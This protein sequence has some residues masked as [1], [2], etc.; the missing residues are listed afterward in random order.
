MSEAGCQSYGYVY[1]LDISVRFQWSQDLDLAQ[2]ARFG[3]GLIFGSLVGQHAIGY[4]RAPH[5]HVDH[6]TMHGAMLEM[7]E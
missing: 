1:C 3:Q 5:C 4:L 2:D 6:V 7:L